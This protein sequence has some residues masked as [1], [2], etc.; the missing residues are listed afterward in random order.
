MSPSA[1][2]LAAQ[3]EEPSVQ[4]MKAAATV[5]EARA[6]YFLP[7]ADAAANRLKFRFSLAAISRSTAGTAIR[8]WLES[9]RIS[10]NRKKEF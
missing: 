7:L 4:A 6:R 3:P 8:P 10:F 2:L 5:I 1:V 9:F